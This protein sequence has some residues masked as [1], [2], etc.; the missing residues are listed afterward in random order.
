MSF[1]PLLSISMSE[2]KAADAGLASAFGNV[3]MQIGAALGLAVL[4]S[5]SVDHARAL[6]A[7]GDSLPVAQ[8]GGYQLAFLLAAVSVVAGLA[9]VVT[10]L[11]TGGG[12]RRQSARVELEQTEAEAA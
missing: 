6:L 8:S 7:H 9:V 2:V 1:L 11:R 5:I 10:F 4:G 12:A 3:S